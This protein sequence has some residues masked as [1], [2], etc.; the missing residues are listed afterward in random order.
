MKSAKPLP[1][2][3]YLRECF[4]YAPHTG[5]LT[6][7]KRPK[8][9]FPH[10]GT[11]VYTNK[12]WAGKPVSLVKHKKPSGRIYLHILIN[13][14]KYPVHRIIFKWM[15]GRDPN[16]VIDHINRDPSDNRWHNLREL[17]G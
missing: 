17:A 5:K 2:Q 14:K 13:S 1:S 7:K 9:H 15:T 16:G 8:H 12:M 4:A 3:Q 10:V 11:M 6:W